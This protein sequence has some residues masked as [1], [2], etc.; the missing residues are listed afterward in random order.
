[1]LPHFCLDWKQRTQD[2]QLCHLQSR[3]SSLGNRPSVATSSICLRGFSEA[4]VRF[5]LGTRITSAVQAPGLAFFNAT[6]APRKPSISAEGIPSLSGIA[7]SVTRD[8]LSLSLALD[9]ETGLES[10]IRSKLC[11]KYQ[12]ICLI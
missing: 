5:H 2:T 12:K 9:F 1:M 10:E 3:Y 11:P 8:L 4:T 6:E 7:Q